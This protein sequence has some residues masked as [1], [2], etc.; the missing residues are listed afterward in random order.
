M[1]TNNLNTEGQPM[2]VS[3]Q[4]KLVE[5]AQSGVA[6]DVEVPNE[7]VRISG[8]AAARVAQD[9]CNVTKSDACDDEGDCEAL[10]PHS[11]VNDQ[12]CSMQQQ[13]EG[14]YTDAFRDTVAEAEEAEDMGICIIRSIASHV[15]YHIFS[16]KSLID[17]S[18]EV[19]IHGVVPDIQTC[20]RSML[21]SNEY[22]GEYDPTKH[23]L[24]RMHHIACV[25]GY[26]STVKAHPDLFDD[27]GNLAQDSAEYK[28]VL[29]KLMS[30]AKAD[31]EDVD[32]YSHQ[33]RT[34]VFVVPRKKLDTDPAVRCPKHVVE[35]VLVTR[36][37]EIRR[38]E[39][40][41]KD[42]GNYNLF[43]DK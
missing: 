16:L 2:S 6:F 33:V 25:V 11:E 15:V 37:M 28:L 30:I 38:M 18:S 10:A 22:E 5:E 39:D 41:D 9:Q 13:Q 27:N 14:L 23:R 20:P 7:G 43:T 24:G 12:A 42:L 40:H 21:I 29:D 32:S 19:T 34:N 3:D 31:V 8:Q 26:E 1:K 17:G 35:S 4:A 36:G